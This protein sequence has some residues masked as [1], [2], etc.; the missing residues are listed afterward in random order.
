M[1]V[2]ATDIELKK[3]LSLAFFIFFWFVY[4]SSNLLYLHNCRHDVRR[5]IRE[6]KCVD[7]RHKTTCRV[8]IDTCPLLS[9]LYLFFVSQT[10]RIRVEKR[11]K[12]KKRATQQRNLKASLNE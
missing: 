6:A 7:I 5:H 9:F 1:E 10:N 11:K 12:K 2:T 8:T 4:V 3:S